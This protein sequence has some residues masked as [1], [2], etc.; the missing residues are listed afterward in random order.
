MLV[1]HITLVLQN[2]GSGSQNEG[3]WMS[4]VRNQIKAA[5]GYTAAIDRDM[6]DVADVFV[7]AMKDTEEKYAKVWNDV[8]MIMMEKIVSYLL[9]NGTTHILDGNSHS[10]RWVAYYATFFEEL[11]AVVFH[12]SQAPFLPEAYPLFLLG[13]EVQRSEI[14]Y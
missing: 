3:G 12:K 13:R 4:N 14:N 8:T 1:L 7:A 5:C 9:C 2:L 10:A 6:E 11:I